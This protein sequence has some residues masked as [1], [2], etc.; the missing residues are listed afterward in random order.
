MESLGP[1]EQLPL[2]KLSRKLAFLLAITSA[3]RGSELVAHDLRF[4]RFHPEG[5]SFNLPE[6]TKGVRVGKPLKTSFYS[7]FPENKLLCPCSCLK[8]YELRTQAF[9]PESIS[10]P[11][12][13]FLSVN[14]PHK[15]VGSATL[16]QWVKKCLLEA[17]IDSQVFKA[18]SK[19][20]AATSAALRAGISIPEIV[21]LADW[22]KG[23]TF[24][25]FCYRPLWNACVGRSVLFSAAVE[26]G[27]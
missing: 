21:R 7:S 24:K 14:K 19:R 25:T 10:E 27:A 17:G 3:E 6:L 4:K 23:T 13:L 22:T 16:S 20:G 1:N 26:Q 5:V 2:K 8:E 15:P 11:N 9:R 12:K 18:H